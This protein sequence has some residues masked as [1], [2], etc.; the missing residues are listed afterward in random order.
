MYG[1]FKGIPEPDSGTAPPGGLASIPASHKADG[2]FTVSCPRESRSQWSDAM[3]TDPADGRPRLARFLASNLIAALAAAGCGGGN[4]SGDTTVV[5]KEAPKRTADMYNF[6]KEK[7][8][9]KGAPTGAP[10]DAPKT[11]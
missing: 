6:M 1:I 7:G 4:Q 8:K 3:L 9:V 2:S 5:A 10:T 11:E